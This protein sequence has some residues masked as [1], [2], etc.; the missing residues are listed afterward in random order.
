MCNCTRNQISEEAENVMRLTT[1]GRRTTHVA[2][3]TPIE[4]S[5]E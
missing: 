4:M 3:Q 5:S 2:G 1:N